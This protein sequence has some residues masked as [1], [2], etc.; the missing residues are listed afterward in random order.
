MILLIAFPLVVGVGLV[1]WLFL[2]DKNPEGNTVL[3]ESKSPEAVVQKQI[4]KE[5]LEVE[6]SPSPQ[7]EAL[8]EPPS[9]DQS[10]PTQTP[11]TPQTPKETLSSLE[12]LTMSSAQKD[13]ILESRIGFGSRLSALIIDGII[14]SI[15]GIVLGVF[16]GK[17]L[18]NIFSSGRG[19]NSE[20]A[21]AAGV[22][23]TI[24]GV[25]YGLAIFG[26]LYGLIEA[27]TGASPGKR[28]IKVI[29][30]NV[31]GAKAS[32]VALFLRFAIKNV[33]SILSLIGGFLGLSFLSAVSGFA[34]IVVFIGCFFALSSRKQALHD[35]IVKTAV[36]RIEE[37]TED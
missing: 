19:L 16:F 14:S 2:S 25:V 29:I 13:D 35:M 11:Q 21:Q 36:Y 1:A 34:G 3:K 4:V 7:Q 12:Q 31:D 17:M 22:I 32:I 6:K 8:K 37:A 24:L 30:R 15:G 20:V 10:L 9:V 23:G 5:D 18:V 27:I 28:L 26:L 33:A